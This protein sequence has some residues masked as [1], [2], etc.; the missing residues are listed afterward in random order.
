MDGLLTPVSTTYRASKLDEPFLTEVKDSSRPSEVTQG[1]KSAS[2]TPSSLDDAVD[3]LRSQPEYDDLISTLRFLTGTAKGGQLGQSKLAPGPKS[4]AVVHTLVTDIAT[5]YWPL[6]A[7][8]SL[9]GDSNTNGSSSSDM[10]LF[11]RC[12][13]SVTGLNAL[14]AQI[15]AFTQ[16]IKSQAKERQRP[17]LPLN[18]RLLLD[19]LAAILA[20][21]DSIRSI[22]SASIAGCANDSQI[23]GQSQA[24]VL[25]L[26]SGRL[27]AAAAEASEHVDEQKTRA[28]SNWTADGLAFTR[29]IGRNLANWASETSADHKDFEVLSNLFQRA[30]SMGYQGEWCFRHARLGRG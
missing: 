4:A 16:E 14:L 11:I 18:L 7:E 15:K 23:K 26:T 22:W 29:W 9:D 6:L 21:D 25:I 24:L 19:L 2:G 10:T 8:G 20:G 3:I 13:R 28:D 1:R 12:L 5:N 17:D 30:L 27:Q